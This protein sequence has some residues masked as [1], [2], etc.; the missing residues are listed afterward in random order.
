M[1]REPHH[2]IP[3]H[4]P[5]FTRTTDGGGLP[6]HQAEQADHLAG[7]GYLALSAYQPVPSARQPA[8]TRAASSFGSVV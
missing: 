1:S 2:R 7:L 4:P 8:F 6:R 3:G 5:R